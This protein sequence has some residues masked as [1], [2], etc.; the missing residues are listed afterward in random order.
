M[1]DVAASSASAVSPPWSSKSIPLLAIAP[2]R[3]ARHAGPMLA[4]VRSGTLR[5]IDALVG[6]VEVDVSSGLP[7]TTTVGLPDGAVREGTERIRAALRNC[8]FKHAERRVTVNLGPAGVRKE[9]A[10]FDL[11]IA[12]G[13]LTAFGDFDLPDLSRWCVLGE[14]GLDGRVH[15]VRGA[16]PLAAAASRAAP[17]ALMVPAVNAPEAPLA[18]GPPVFGVETLAEAVP[19]LRRGAGRPPTTPHPPPPL[20]PHPL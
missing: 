9:G 20:R 5:G 13:L 17:V 19:P 11:P 12:L 3:R 10:A 15:G 16:L 7:H 4:R 2:A 14:L 18:G 8:G 1:L 6:D